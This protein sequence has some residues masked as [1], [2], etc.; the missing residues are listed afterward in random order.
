M[1]TTPDADWAGL[2]ARFTALVDQLIAWIRDQGAGLLLGLAAAALLA[3]VLLGLRRLGSQLCR[4]DTTGQGWTAIIGRAVNRTGNL[5]ILAV[6]ARLVVNYSDAP[7]VIA[8]PVRIAFVVAATLQVALWAREIIIGLIEY[9]TE[10]GQHNALGSALGIIRLLVTVALFIIATIVILD[11]IGVNV[12][13][14]VA[15]LGIGGIAIGLAAQGIFA[16]LFAA[17]SILFDRPFRRGDAIAYDQTSATVEAI[18]LKSTRLRSVSGE[19]RVISNKQL[20]DKEIR[21]M[22]RLER[23]RGRFLLS[24]VYHTDPQQAAALPALLRALVEGLGHQFVRAGFVGFAASSLDFELEFDVESDDFET[25][26]AARHALGM[27]ILARFRS[28]GLE[29]AYPTQTTLTA[30]PDGRLIMP[31]ATAADRSG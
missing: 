1:P 5:F 6:A 16:D 15:G 31:Y 27:A 2:S 10:A 11:N 25:F 21:N 13:G 14:L 24:L 30:A 19:Q 26:V 18:G 7:A 20:L 3:G 28:D 23:R 12:T 29:F 9:R 17:L 22:S 4:R 8:E